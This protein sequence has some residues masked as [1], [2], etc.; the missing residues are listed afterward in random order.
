MAPVV[1]S[2]A[3]LK[4][5]ARVQ[6]YSYLGIGRTTKHNAKRVTVKLL[7]TTNYVFADGECFLDLAFI[8]YLPNK[9][10]VGWGNG[11]CHYKLDRQS[12]F[13]N[14]IKVASEF[15][16][17]VLVAL[18]Q[19]QRVTV[20]KCA[21]VFASPYQVLPQTDNE[22]AVRTERRHRP[23]LVVQLCAEIGKGLGIGK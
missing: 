3:V 19:R 16:T 17:P 2:W 22:T 7:Q 13:L 21:L 1:G 14:D 12:L 20:Y 6:R 18:P 9:I 15:L 23:L 4:K 5:C 11:V 10:C 8:C